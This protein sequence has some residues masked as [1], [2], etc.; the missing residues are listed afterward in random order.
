M[1]EQ[2]FAHAQH[3][4]NL[5]ILRMF[6]GI[7]LLDVANMGSLDS[8][9]FLFPLLYCPFHGAQRRR[10]FSVSVWT[11]GCSFNLFVDFKWG[12]VG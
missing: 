2:Y 9:H 6:E 3:D 5:S 11:Q 10:A 8:I 4:L 12:P 7:Y 1:R